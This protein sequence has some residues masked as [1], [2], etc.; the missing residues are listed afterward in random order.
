[1]SLRRQVRVCTGNC[2][3]RPL[4]KLINWN[5]W[6]LCS[7]RLEVTAGPA[8]V[9]EGEYLYERS[10]KKTRQSVGGGDSSVN[11]FRQACLWSEEPLCLLMDRVP[12]A[13]NCRND[14][15]ETLVSGKFRPLCK[16]KTKQKQNPRNKKRALPLNMAISSFEVCLWTRWKQMSEHFSRGTRRWLM[17][18]KVPLKE[19]FKGDKARQSIMF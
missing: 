14:I 16:K 10:S 19:E 17:G 8:A 11:I 1:M 7:S 5:C 18:S 4:D 2:F 9:E 3:C 13:E 12:H 15:Y 6:Q